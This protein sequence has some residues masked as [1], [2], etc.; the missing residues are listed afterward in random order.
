M[1]GVARENA[2]A[3]GRLNELE[4]G[5]YKICYATRSS[6]RLMP[7]LVVLTLLSQVKLTIAQIFLTCQRS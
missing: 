7:D 4:V 1:A 6:E 2:V 5:T 3:T